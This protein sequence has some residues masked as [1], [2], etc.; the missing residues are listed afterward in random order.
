[1]SIS[2]ITWLRTAKGFISRQYLLDRL[3]LAF[4]SAAISRTIYEVRNPLAPWICPEMVGVLEN[5]LKPS[6]EGFE[7]G[8]GTSTLW[9]G[10]RVQYVHSVEH[11]VVWARKVQGMIDAH[12][13]A[14]KVKVI[15]VGQGDESTGEGKEA[16]IGPIRQFS[17][18]SLD[19]C[20]VDGLFRDA[21]IQESIRV[22]RRGGVLIVDNADTYFP[23]NRVSRSIRYKRDN[24]S[25]TVSRPL[26]ETIWAE[27]AGWRCVWT[28]TPI[29][30]TALWI[31]P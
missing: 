1:M 20:F 27:L 26:M 29:Q 5:V 23:K 15:R 3:D 4:L 11:D 2:L 6:D 30:D 17:S 16:Y 14:G 13:L 7:F 24:F 21:C 8:S 18:E 19:F 9:L 28:T 10:Q 22:L 31:K 12:G 25:R